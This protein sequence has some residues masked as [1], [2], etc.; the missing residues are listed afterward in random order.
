MEPFEES[1]KRRIE[2]ARG[3]RPADLV[4]K[5]GRVVNVFDGTAE[6]A[7]V[8]VQDGLVAGIGPG[9]QGRAELDVDGLWVAPG[10]MDAH[11]H[12]ES[13]MLM[14]PHLA[15]VLLPHGT[16]A[17]VSDPH[18][19]ANVKGLEG[20]RLL[21]EAGRDLPFDIFFMAPSCVPA[22][23]LETSGATLEVEDLRPLLEEPQVLGLAELMNVPG[24]IHGDPAVLGKVALF[25]GR[26]LDGHSPGLSGRDLQAYLTAGIGS[27]HECTQPEEAQEKVRS[28]MFVMIR[29]GTSARNLDAL[30]P[31][32]TTENS[33]RFC[34]VSDDL[35]P[36]DILRRGHLDHMIRRAV[37]AGMDP[38]QA[39]RMASIN[40][41]RYFGF[42]DR[43]A[44]APGYRADLV[45]LSN[46]EAFAVERVMHAGRLVV[47]QGVVRGT[48]EHALSTPG[49]GP[50]ST[51]AL[52][53]ER[54]SIPD[55]G[56]RVRVI[57]LVPGQVHTEEV[58]ARPRIRDGRVRPDPERD[59]LVLA[60]VERH[61]ATGRTG[62]GLVQGFGLRQ[63]ALVSS[64]AHDSH[65]VIAVGAS[66]GDLLRGV[67]TLR[68][69]GGGLAAVR[70]GEVLARVPLPV[71]GLL[72]LEPLEGL[73]RELDE[74]HRAAASLGCLLED[75]FMALSFLAL[76]VIPA[77]KL[78][79][80]G[81]VDVTRFDFVPLGAEAS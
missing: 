24:L 6:R 70:D 80:R 37:H 34:F 71:A 38:V 81:L 62:L 17:I 61:H 69:M 4:L 78:T 16:T 52:E 26:V 45:I 27:D 44:V 79:D 57:R 75:P 55:P 23:H 1:L 18:E 49:T 63:G 73:V 43:G 41:A 2:V 8:A 68:D 29:E 19:I 35:H 13:S 51:G 28:G 25:R 20:V 5:N 53:K 9:Y 11:M 40:P 7:D 15:A 76:P 33:D 74:L 67:E 14:P 12:I 72:S 66:E 42:R 39:I 59:L 58:L 30:L 56:G 10:L 22:T 21:M 46:L 32:V 64:V 36:Q 3:V 48:F 77:L 47:E 50:L 65:N 60:V 54:F 31:V